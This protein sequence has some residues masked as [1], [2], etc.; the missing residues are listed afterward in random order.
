M[1]KRREGNVVRLI[2][3]RMVTPREQLMYYL[4][5]CEEGLTSIIIIGMYEDPYGEGDLVTVQ[6][7]K[8]TLA[9]LGFM[10]RVAEKDIFGSD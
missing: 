8:N 9:N 10:L 2:P 5:Q 1:G 6:C 3:E 7:T 4:G